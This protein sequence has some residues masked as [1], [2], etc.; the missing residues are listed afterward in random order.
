MSEELK[1]CPF[2]KGGETRIDE[3]HLHRGV[4]MNQRPNPVVSAEVKHWC[5]PEEGQPHRRMITMTGRDRESAIKAWNTRVVDP[6]IAELELENNGLC[7]NIANAVDEI[8]LD[9]KRI[10]ELEAQVAQ[11]KDLCHK[12]GAE[13]CL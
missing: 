12:N 11:L 10:T 2:C 1:P 7:Q 13:S 8:E 4:T 5:E 9:Y 3:T 6:L